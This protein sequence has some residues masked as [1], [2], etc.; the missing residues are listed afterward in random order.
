MVDDGGLRRV[1]VSGV[2][3]LRRQGLSSAA[4][5]TDRA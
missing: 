3:G 2:K 5:G 1:D 4:V